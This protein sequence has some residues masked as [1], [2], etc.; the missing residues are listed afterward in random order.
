[1]VLIPLEA[2]D[3]QSRLRNAGTLAVP[4]AW[5]S[6]LSPRLSEPM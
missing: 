2:E 5:P 1:M 4:W 6:A 3:L